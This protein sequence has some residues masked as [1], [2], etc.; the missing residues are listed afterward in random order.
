MILSNLITAKVSV[1]AGIFLG[2]GICY[3]NK[4]I[5]EKQDISKENESSFNEK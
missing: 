2:I 1:V 4:K 5:M 3:L